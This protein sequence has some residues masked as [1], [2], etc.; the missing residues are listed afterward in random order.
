MLQPAV[1][2]VTN[3]LEG[4]DGC[5]VLATTDRPETTAVVADLT[6]TGLTLLSELSV[7]EKIVPPILIPLSA[8]EI[9]QAEVDEVPT[10]EGAPIGVL[11]DGPL[12]VNPLML[13]VV[14][15]EASFPDGDLPV[16]PTRA[17]TGPRSLSMAAFYDFEQHIGAGEP[18]RVPHPIVAA[19]V[20]E[21]SP[22]SPTITKPRG[23]IFEETVEAAIR[24]LHAGGVRVI[25]MSIA[26]NVAATTG[27][28]PDDLTW[29]LD[30]LAR[31]LDM[32]IV[33]SA[34]NTTE[35]SGHYA[36]HHYPTY[37][38]E[39]EAGIGEPGLAA[40]ALTVGG[41]A[42]SGTSNLPNWQGIAPSGGAS[43]FTRTG[44]NAGS[45]RLKPDLVHWAGNW[46]WNDHLQQVATA[47]P[48]LSVVVAATEPG[49]TFDWKSGTSFAAPRVAH[50][51]AEILTNYPDA[52]ANLVRAL[53][54][55]STRQSQTMKDLFPDRTQRQRAAGAGLPDRDLAVASG[56][57]RVVLTFEGSI[58]CDT[59]IVHPVPIPIEFTHGRHRRRICIAVACD[60]PVRR[61]RREYVAGH[62]QISL[63]RAM[64][65][66]EVL[67]VF[68]HQPGAQARKNDPSLTVTPLPTDRRRPTLRPG[69]DDVAR[70]TAYVS[71]SSTVQ[72]QED[73]GDTYYVA[74]TH[75]KSPW[76]NLTTYQEQRYAIAVELVD[77]GEQ[78]I[79]LYNLVRARISGP[80][81]PTTS[82]D[83]YG[84]II[85]SAAARSCSKFD[86]IT[87][88]WIAREDAP[89]SGS[90]QI[91]P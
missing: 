56:G 89:I 70:T 22:G 74:V 51:A 3:L 55:L 39:P 46:A 25:N 1:E 83:P 68:R 79:D 31:E 84:F 47:D 14:T 32:V 15:S 29:V 50:I 80:G 66:D 76:R 60:P 71:E 72:L 62:L 67:D 27:A 82:L 30:S 18:L 65:Q 17:R 86:T 53:V 38:G 10:P 23:I 90:S 13:K 54:L 9:E 63:V 6:A 26:R 24:W 2:R 78:R 35:F 58:G 37:L 59:T 48:S 12:L 75:Q 8:S 64:A 36:A 43:P 73:D 20:I 41:Q 40:N 61:T 44:V 69:P 21:P 52:T 81:S 34:G 11:D 88:E 49:R 19:R 33:L 57:N 4:V 45:G 87:P 85:A 28:L 91:Q 7:V 5:Q 77:E 16:E 42:R